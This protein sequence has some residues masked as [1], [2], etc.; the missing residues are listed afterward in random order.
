MKNIMLL[1]LFAAIAAITGC[2]KTNISAKQG[3]SLPAVENLALQPVS[4]TEVKLSWQMP[5]TIPAEINQPLNVLI[6][7]KEQLNTG[8]T[9]PVFN[10]TLTGAPTE[11]LYTLPDK[12]KTYLLTV[13]L[14][15]GVKEPDVNYS[16]NIIS[17]GQTVQYN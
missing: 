8:R 9:L 2:V 5:K 7:V 12:A 11:F 3:V 6:E 13:K 15:G 1:I 16:S 17:L 4:E 10:T 14:N